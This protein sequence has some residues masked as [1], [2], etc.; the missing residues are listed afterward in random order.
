M[1]KKAHKSAE[2]TP[3][4][5]SHETPPSKL[6]PKPCVTCGRQITPRAKWAKNWGE[7]R[8]CSDSCKSFKPSSRAAVFQLRNL[9]KTVIDNVRS[10]LN[11]ANDESVSHALSRFLTSHPETHDAANESIVRAQVDVD[12]WIEHALVSTS[13]PQSTHSGNLPS[14]DALELRLL[15]AASV[16]DRLVADGKDAGTDSLHHYLQSSGPGMRERVRR[17]ARRL[18]VLDQDEMSTGAGRLQLLQNGKV[19]NGLEGASFAKGSIQYRRPG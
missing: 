1:V 4:G 14:C 10:G 19:L 12:T 11:A 3:L 9:H 6:A 7:I 8:T 16:F 18:F 13:P 2:E 17:A 15:Q 5:H